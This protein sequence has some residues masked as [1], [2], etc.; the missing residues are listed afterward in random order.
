MLTA[1]R[2][3]DGS[4]TVIVD[5]FVGGLCA[6]VHWLDARSSVDSESASCFIV[7]QLAHELLHV[8]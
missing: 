2:G 8:L 4:G 7:L 1:Y 6:A 5:N 3:G